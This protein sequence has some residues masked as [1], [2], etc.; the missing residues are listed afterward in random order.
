MR[1]GKLAKASRQMIAGGQNR[2]REMDGAA[3]TPS[4]RASIEL[5][6]LDQPGSSRAK[7]LS[8]AWLAEVREMRGR[9]CYDGGHRPSFQRMNGGFD[10]ADE[11]D[12]SAYHVVAR[13]QDRVVGCAR[14]A[15]LAGIQSC[16]VS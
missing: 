11:V 6:F 10:D 14:V 4:V 13:S 2:A 1:H 3:I 5:R 12:L 16:V 9:V 7:A 15:P 8:S